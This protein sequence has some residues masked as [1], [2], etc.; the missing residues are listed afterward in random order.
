MYH[1]PIGKRKR[2]KRAQVTSRDC[3]RWQARLPRRVVGCVRPRT[4]GPRRPPNAAVDFFHQDCPIGVSPAALIRRGNDT[5]KRPLAAIVPIQGSTERLFLLQYLFRYFCCNLQL[6]I[7]IF[8]EDRI[9]G[10]QK[11]FLGFFYS[12][13]Y[14]PK[15]N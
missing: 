7:I 6:A 4:G 8:S 13:R 5:S 15:L 9:R 12:V 11:I 10:F 2:G 1:H 3:R 14:C